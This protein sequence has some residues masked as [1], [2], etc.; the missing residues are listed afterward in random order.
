MKQRLIIFYA[1]LIIQHE[2]Y[3]LQMTKALIFQE[4]LASGWRLYGKGGGGGDCA[5]GLEVGWFVGWL[6]KEEL[7]FPF[8]YLICDKKIEYVQL[9][10]RV[11][12]L[13]GENS[14]PASSDPTWDSS[15]YNS[16]SGIPVFD[17]GEELIDLKN[18]K[19]IAYI[20]RPEDLCYTKMRKTVYTKLCQAQDILPPG[21]CFLVY[22][23]Y[24]S[25]KHQ[26][27]LF[28]QKMQKLKERY[29]QMSESEIFAEAAKMVSPLV[30]GSIPPHSTGGAVDLCLMNNEG[31]VLNMGAPLEK[32]LEL[33]PNILCTDSM[34]ISDI[35]R[36]NRHI[37]GTALQAVG[38][39]NYEREYWHWSYGD[40]RWAYYSG[41]PYAVYGSIED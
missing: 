16:S 33:D 37:M 18:Q 5:D 31:E 21:H 19:I 25:L 4:E 23:A 10:P 13:I 39:V 41:S 32:A 29:P 6:E 9:V 30:E 3:A 17:N 14:L 40:R 12:Q 24:R 27:E 11:K 28:Q 38:F 36:Q 1:L 22:T 35:A 20:D 26:R 7:F 2:G 8:A 15:S 34:L